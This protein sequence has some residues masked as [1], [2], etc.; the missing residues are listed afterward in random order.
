MRLITVSTE[1]PLPTPQRT[2]RWPK[3]IV[4]IGVVAVI[5]AG[6]GAYL[7]IRAV[8][9]PGSAPASGQPP[10]R[11]GAAIAYDGADGTVIMFGGQGKSASLGD[12]WTWDGSA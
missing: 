11:T 1:A 2:R 10:A 6:L 8:A 3:A 5:G 7:G 4:G 9:G 12:T